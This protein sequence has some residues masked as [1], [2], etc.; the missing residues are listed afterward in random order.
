MNSLTQ[1]LLKTFA[2]ASEVALR[3]DHN[4]TRDPVLGCE[5]DRAL[6]AWLDAMA[7][8]ADGCER[9]KDFADDMRKVIAEN[10][11]PDERHCSCVPH[12]R[13]RIEEMAEE[14]RRAVDTLN[15]DT[16]AQLDALQ[17][18]RDR[19]RLVLAAERGDPEG[20]P[21]GWTST[22]SGWR[23]GRMRVRRQGWGWQW[24]ILG[25]TGRVP[26]KEK[27][28]RAAGVADTAWEAMQAAERA[29]LTLTPT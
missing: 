20:A 1:K 22:E 19:L 12:L 8:D 7:P 14:Y 26:L 18:E 21:P 17:R 24:V 3:V 16:L 28:P 5:I 23:K 2:T 29:A 27:M 15:A 6:I 9:C 25:A 13:T 10:Y 4:F 11:A